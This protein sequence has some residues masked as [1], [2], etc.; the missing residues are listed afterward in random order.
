V[1]RLAGG[2]VENELQTEKKE[3]REGTCQVHAKQTSHFTQL[4]M[5][6]KKNKMTK[7]SENTILTGS[8]H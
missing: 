4:K 3:Q 8:I 6:K 5:E 7:N 1:G 2:C